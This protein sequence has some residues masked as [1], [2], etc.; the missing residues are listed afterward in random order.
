MQL[1][2][3][4]DFALLDMIP[5]YVS[6]Q[7]TRCYQDA[8][9]FTLSLN[10]L[11]H[12][13]CLAIG[14]YIMVNDDTLIIE[15]IHAYHDVGGEFK[16]EATGRQLS[17]ILD[18]RIIL[19][20]LTISTTQTFE[21]QI[22]NLVQSHFISPT[23]TKRRVPFLRASPSKGISVK[24]VE[25]FTFENTDCLSII[26]ILCQESALGFRIRFHPEDGFMEFEVYKG[27]DLAEEVFFSE[28]YSNIEYS[29]LY[30]QSRDMKNVGYLSKDGT[31]TE[32]ANTI[33]GLERREIACTGTDTSEV[34]KTLQ[35][36]GKLMSAECGV[37]SKSQF[38]YREDWDIGDTVAFVD[39]VL[40]FKVEKPILEVA[41]NYSDTF[42]IDL[43]C[44]DKIPTIFEKLGRR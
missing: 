19:S 9:N 16:L 10:S 30:E 22:Y 38:V 15:N 37:L 25:A 34:A 32:M 1:Y 2:I 5:Q 33:A 14:S 42:S 21:A 13:D 36:K 3:F 6:Y 8:G 7:Q 28:D 40:G 29:E 18:R 20:K 11:E 43:V 31:T 41:E 44:G 27:S 17:S 35:S 26:K 23:D 39:N 24:P 4:K 12:K